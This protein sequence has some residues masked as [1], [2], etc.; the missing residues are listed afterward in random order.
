MG[1]KALINSNITHSVSTVTA[2][3]RG[4]F[5]FLYQQ[6]Q[7]PRLPAPLERMRSKFTV[8]ISCVSKSGSS[9]S[10][11]KTK[12]EKNIDSSDLSWWKLPPTPIKSMR[13]CGCV[14]TRA[15]LAVTAL[16]LLSLKATSGPWQPQN[17]QSLARLA[18]WEAVVGGWGG[19]DQKFRDVF[20][21]KRSVPEDALNM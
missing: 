12:K 16:L 17:N 6:Q 15:A 18:S 13:R 5:S 4:I 14:I 11:C 21:Q 1:R 20:K 9:M 2:I 8:T 7:H 3:T 10:G 19:G